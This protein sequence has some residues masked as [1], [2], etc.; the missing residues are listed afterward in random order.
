MSL[1]PNTLYYGDCLE[2]L[3]RF[4]PESVDLI[5]LDPPFN[6]NTN[7]NLLFGNGQPKR[8]GRTAQVR[9]FDDT[10]R[11][12]D[13]AAKRVDRL[14]RAAGHPAHKAVAGLRV[15]VGDGGMLAYLS[16]MAERLAAMRHVLKPTGSIYLHCDPTASHGLKLVMDTIFGAGNF[17]NEIV[18]RRSNAHNKLSRQYGPIHDVIL[19]YA[20]GDRS[21]FHPGRRLYTKT[22]IRDAFR[23]RDERGRYQTNVLTGPGKRRGDSGKPWRGYDPTERGRHWAIPQALK[24]ALPEE[25][26]TTGTL[27]LLDALAS[28]GELVIS[29]NGVPRYKQRMGQG[30]QYQDIWAYQPGTGGTLH[31]DDTEI[32][33]DVKW[34]DAESERLG[35]PTQKPVGLLERI[36]ESSTNPDDVILDPF[37]G[38][39]TAVVAAHKLN[40]RWAGIDISPFAI[41]LIREKRFPEFHVPTE[42][43]PY[44]LAGAAKLARE[45][46]F[47]FEKWAV[48]RVPGLAP[49]DRQVGDGGIDGV[50]YLLAKPDNGTTGQVLAQVKGGKYRLGQLRDFLGVM[51]RE[52]AAIGVY[53]TVE[54]IRAAGAHAEAAR[55]GNLRLGATE[56]PRA[57]LWSMRDYFDDRMPLLPALADPYTGKPV[58]SSLRMSL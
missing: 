33:R 53:T 58:Q 28:Q 23:H 6:S 57:Q 7:Y 16:Y 9:A 8:G 22:Y 50:G 38:C 27:E 39:G 35:Y 25:Y 2:W 5:Y 47:K 44:D 17:R 14:S 24:E 42:G 41:D 30:V 37:C 52:Q 32:D 12:D 31:G 45:Q 19:F 29:R 1:E 36:I 43:Y 20:A 10:W 51:E 56:Y 49:N 3:P 48:T 21:T 26:R 4:P 18:W 34:L 54:P 40:R 46:P 15:L 13:A 11:W 55:R